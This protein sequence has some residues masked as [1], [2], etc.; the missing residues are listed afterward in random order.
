M[1][2]TWKT[3]GLAAALCVGL[4]G[5]GSDSD[6]DAG[7]TSTTTTT[8]A[9]KAAVCTARDDLKQSVGDLGDL[10]VAEEGKSGVTAAVTTVNQDF[11]ELQSVASDTYKPQLDDVK[12]ALDELQTAVG[13]LG[14][15]DLGQETQD[16]G[17]A[18]SKVSETTTTL[19][20]TLEEECPSG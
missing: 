18:I 4:A 5:C 14:S 19:F 15:G 3:I 12:S 8:E 6:S 20:T 13:N 1:P 9:G 10:S 17:A 16:A 2:R 7:S 11:E